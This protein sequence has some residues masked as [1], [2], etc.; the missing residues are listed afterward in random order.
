MSG[1]GKSSKQTIGYKFY[2]G[3]A[4]V[5]AKYVSRLLHIKIGDKMAWQGS[6]SGEAQASINKELL[7]GT[8]AEG[9]VVGTFAFRAGKPDQPADPY[10][11]SKLGA[12]IS[13]DRG[14]SSLVLRQP[15]MGNNPYIKDIT[16]RA[17][18][19]HE[20]DGGYPQWYD[21]KSEISFFSSLSLSSSVYIALDNSGS[22]AGTKLANLKSAMSIVFDQLQDFVAAGASMNI[23]LVIWGGVVENVVTKAS[24]SVGDFTD[25]RN[26]VNAM[27]AT[28]SGTNAV[29]AY[30][31]ALDF[32]SK[33]IP[34]NNI[35]C[36]VSD[37]E[38][39]DTAAALAMGVADMVD[40]QNEPYSLALGT[41]INMRGVGIGTAGS[42]ALFDNSG[43]SIPVVSGSNSEELANAI[44][45]VLNSSLTIRDINPAHILRE[46]LTNKEWGYGY[47]DEDLDDASFIS[48]AD[49]LYSEN[50]GLS[51][52]WEDDSTL[53]TVVN[54]VLDHI[55]G[56]LYVNR[57]NLKW[58][59]ALVRNDY[60]VEDLIEL[61]ENVEVVSISNYKKP[62]FFDLVNTV[63]VNFYNSQNGGNGSMSQSNAALFLQQGKRIAKTIDY[64]MCCRAGLAAVLLQ[65][66]LDIR[67]NPFS[68]CE[69]L[70]TSAAKNLRRG[71]VFKLTHSRYNYNQT[72]MRVSEISYG[73]GKTKG[74][75]I[76]CIEDRFALPQ[77]AGV[78]VQPPIVEPPA[79]IAPL[80]NRMVME[81]PYAMLISRLGQSVIDQQL[82]ADP[83]L[84]FFGASAARASG[85]LTAEIHTDNG[86]GYEQVAMLDFCPYGEL[87]STV[88]DTETEFLFTNTQDL[89]E[90][91][92]SRLFQIDSE[93]M[94]FTA[95]DISTGAATGILRGLF[96]TLPTMHAAGA[97]A[98][99]FEDYFDGGVEQ[100]VDGEAIDVKLLPTTPQGKLPLVLAPVD[101]LEFVGR[102]AR[103]YP[104]ANLKVNGMRPVVGDLTG[105]VEVTWNHRDRLGQADQFVDWYEGD[106]GP[107][108]GVTYTLRVR[109][110]AG[111][112]L[113]HEETDIDSNSA[114]F[115]VEFTGNIKVEALSVRDGIESMYVPSMQFMYINTNVQAFTTSG[116]FVVPEGVTEIDVLIVGG[117]GGGGSRQGAGGGGGG[118]RFIANMAVTPEDSIAVVVGAGGAGGTAGGRGTNGSNSSFGVEVSIGGGAGGGRT[119]NPTGN[120]GGSGGGSARH[121]SQAAGTG[122]AGQGYAGGLASPANADGNAAGGGG[123]AG[124]IGGNASGVNE[125]GIGG[126]GGAGL[127]FADFVAYGAAGW[128][129]GGGGGGTSRS[130]V[131]GGGAMNSPGTGGVGGGG[132]GTGF[133]PYPP[134]DVSQNG[135]SGLPNTGGGGGGS[136]DPASS[137]GAGGSGIVIVKWVDP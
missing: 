87:G 109:T 105:E 113:I 22:M 37:G 81:E 63:T 11:V 16:V 128:F 50:F 20:L 36:I 99:F 14:V 104:P 114:N 127:Y 52:F 135:Y 103:P 110:V 88:S 71:S 62:Q 107:E 7:F 70:A 44:I 136:N 28:G 117:G 43:G 42:L 35:C 12:G 41:F 130:G 67:S 119:T 137:G 68:Q 78:E 29:A 86:S 47:E 40:T 65:R 77:S 76:Q 10:L 17:E 101:T 100:Y 66:E 82:T 60:D 106:V 25:L 64:P 122:T 53:D 124:Q 15:Y 2:C 39:T 13:A 31:P 125:S 58:T 96:D 57:A 34:G 49:K 102:A 54:K 92:N 129:G 85:A 115:E 24:A 111:N 21:E 59:L 112:V 32:F 123:G 56:V 98:F 46:C 18:R 4:L 84:G 51:Y 1:G 74:I 26:A 48:V 23:R 45:S 75:K 72:V 19:I 108:V 33:T 94:A 90:L 61:R 38:M 79:S 93:I 132:A 126:N 27:G 30:S 116:T 3:A 118:V 83:S 95:L 8:K 91:G 131:G 5:I 9:G 120:N 133:P 134:G 6:M 97:S 121:S 73:D 69:V 55:D 89:D 80:E